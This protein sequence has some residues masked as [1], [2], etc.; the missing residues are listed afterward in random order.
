MKVAVIGAGYVGQVTA[1]GLSGLGHDVLLI[2]AQNER[3]I[4]LRRGIS[5][6]G[7]P[8]LTTSLVEQLGSGRLTVE[9]SIEHIGDEHEVVFIC[10][11]TPCPPE[12]DC[13]PAN[14]L[15]AASQLASHLGTLVENVSVVIK[16]T[17]PPGTTRSP[18]RQTLAEASGVAAQ[19]IRSG[20]VPEFLREGSALADF[21]DPDRI[22]L[23][24]DDSV[25]MARL[26][27]LFSSYNC[28]KFTVNSATAEFSKYL[29]NTFL[30]LL[31]SFSNE[32]RAISDAVE[33][34]DFA[35]TL[36]SLI[37]DRR[38][39]TGG[40]PAPEIVS[41]LT[42]GIGFGGSCLPKDTRALIW[43][44]EERG[45]TPQI[46]PAIH[47]INLN[48]ADWLVERLE[49]QGAFSL[50][51]RVLLLGLSF[52]PG[53]TDIRESPSL[54]LAERLLAIGV[55]LKMHDPEA[56][57]EVTR[58]RP[59]IAE[60]IVDDWRREATCADTIVIATAWPIY[61][62]LSRMQLTG[63]IFD[64]RGLLGGTF[65]LNDVPR[66]EA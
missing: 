42:P 50:G 55:D 37:S 16:S 41:Y 2:E 38:L 34:V 30:A 66:A 10:V 56:S 12:S 17:V 18:L 62:E 52:K 49:A 39:S 7:E 25:T 58:S 1:V 45:Y 11:G 24:A 19:R 53:T 32:M 6:L 26:E 28:P 31:I 4:E 43:A 54:R 61:R 9:N 14:V 57:A 3:C 21:D 20:M 36:N 35:A 23:G 33:G 59:E 44:A 27:K 65:S 5:T 64:P 13:T 15:D 29:S 63:R 40:T 8:G 22:V 46:L 48:Q 60:L 47:A 51:T